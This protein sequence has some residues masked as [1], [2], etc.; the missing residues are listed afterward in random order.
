MLAAGREPFEAIIEAVDGLAPGQVLVLRS[1]FDPVP[2]HRVLAGRGFWRESRR[3]ADDDWETVYHQ[4]H[5]R[6]D[7]DVSRGPDPVAGSDD[8]AAAGDEEHARILDVRGLMPPEPLE[9]TLTA[10]EQLGRGER[11][12]HINERIPVFLLPVLDERGYEYAL[13]EADGAVRLTV[14]HG[15]GASR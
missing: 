8:Q 10:L 4:E 5:D 1:P 14:W 13:E 7:P 15:D 11:L 3:M 2:L 9:R 12:L 6:G